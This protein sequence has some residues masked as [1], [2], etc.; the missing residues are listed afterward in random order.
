MVQSFGQINVYDSG[1]EVQIC[2]DG[3]IKLMNAHVKDESNS[4]EHEHERRVDVVTI[5]PGVLAAIMDAVRKK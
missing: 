3:T 1:G 5:Q 4:A 2:R